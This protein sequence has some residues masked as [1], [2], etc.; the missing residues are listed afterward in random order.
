MFP[1]TLT[2]EQRRVMMQQKY[3]EAEPWAREALS[4]QQ[5]VS[6]G[7]PLVASTGATLGFA[8]IGLEQYDEAEAILRKA[9]DLAISTVGERRTGQLDDGEQHLIEAYEMVVEAA[10]ETNPVA[11]YAAVELAALYDARGATDPD[12]GWQAKAAEWRAKKG[13]DPVT[14]GR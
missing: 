4:V 12:G 8:L 13:T 7:H 2:E 11:E 6:P 14:G 3:A 5:L 1:F 10:G 9:L